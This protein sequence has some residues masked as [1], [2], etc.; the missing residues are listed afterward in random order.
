MSKG[1]NFF[2]TS[3]SLVGSPNSLAQVPSLLTQSLGLEEA[4]TEV[5][6]GAGRGRF[7]GEKPRVK[8]ELNKNSVS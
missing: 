1:D 2:W 3:T 4:H 6:P 8:T 7:L 5:G